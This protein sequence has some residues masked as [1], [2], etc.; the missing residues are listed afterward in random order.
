MKAKSLLQLIFFTSISSSVLAGGD[1]GPGDPD[2]S[3]NDGD[4]ESDVNPM[5]VPKGNY[6]ILE[7][8]GVKVLN[9]D[10]FAHFI[11]P[12][13]IVL[14]EFYA[15]WC[16]H[17]KTLEPEYAKAAQILQKDGIPLAKVDATKEA[18]LAKEYMIQGFPTLILFKKGEKVE[19]YDGQRTTKDIVEYMKK[20]S[21]PNYKP[22][23]SVVV[24]LTTDN[25]TKY[26]KNEKLTLAMFYAP[27]CKHCKQVEPEIEGAAAELKEWGIKIVKVDGTREK[28]LADQYGIIGWP[29][30]KM[31][32]KGRIYNYDGPR[33]KDN[34][35]AFMKNQ[36]KPPS[37]EKSSRLGVVNNM[38]RL[39]ATVVGFFKGSASEHTDLFDEYIVAANEMRGSLK[40]LHTFSDE[41]AK[42]YKFPQETIVVFQPEIFWSPYENK[43]YSISKKSAT[44][45]EIL[46]FIR[47]SSIPLVGQRTK[48]N[49]FKYTERP[50]VVVYYDVNYDHQYVKDTQFI[51]KKVL[52]VAKEYRTSNLHFAISNEDE[53]ADEIKGLGL[54]DGGEDVS[55]GC[56][57]EKQ[58][59][60]Y[61]L[62][63]DFE[64]E[65]LSNF[66]NLLRSGRVS[67]YMKSLPVPQGEQGLVKNLVA[68]NYDDEIHKIK[69]DAVIFFHAPWCGH[70]KDLDPVFKKVAKKISTNNENVIFGKMNGESNDIPYMFPKLKGFPSL[71]FISAYDKFDPILYQGDK[72]YKSIRDWINRHSSIFLTEEERTGEAALEDDEIESYTNE[73]FED[74]LT[75]PH[76]ESVEDNGIESKDEL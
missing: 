36:Y 48:S 61:Q 58:K 16:G 59:F 53:F 63:G 35:I 15:P 17:C 72:N 70:C 57:S 6:N 28:E 33:E 26:I 8:D 76:V 56:Y 55:I 27:W 1:D 69:K 44:Y 29:T 19:Q 60:R 2:F 3:A 62:D 32:R 38:D 66:I 31:F 4:L 45:K 34:I 68:N 21:D 24:V 73:N 14:V 49:M 40:F 43:T 50:L 20:Q 9:R 25:F 67:P 7:I 5:E 75:K 30:F 39:E 64:S 74:D 41:V 12:K 18:S 37:E 51:R 11:K 46:Q 65:Y 71:F 54:E 23:P 47:K 42:S 52:E 22:P 10:T 13:D